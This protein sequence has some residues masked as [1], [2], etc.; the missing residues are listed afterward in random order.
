[1][2]LALEREWYDDRTPTDSD[3]DTNKVRVGHRFDWGRN[4][5][6]TSRL[7]YFDRSQFNPF[8]RLLIEE[9]LRIQHAANLLSSTNYQFTRGEQEQDVT[10]HAGRFQLTHN[11]YDNLT[12]TGH[13]LGSYQD[14]EVTEETI[15]EGGLDF[16]Y[17]K[18]I[19]RGVAFTAGLGGSYRVTDRDSTDEG[20]LTKFDEKDFVGATT[21][22]FLLDEQFIDTETIEIRDD[23]EGGG[24]L[25][26]ENV[27][28]EVQSIG[29]NQTEIIVLA[30]LNAR[31]PLT[32]YSTYDYEPEPTEKFSTADFNYNLGLDFGWIAIYRDYSRQD[33]RRISGE[34]ATSLIDR[35]D[36]RTGLELKWLRPPASAT[37][38]AERRFLK[39]G[40][41][42][43]ETYTLRESAVYS[44]APGLTL[45]LSA[46]QNF[47]DADNQ[48][49][50]LYTGDL[51]LE[52]RPPRS[53]LFVRP[54]VSA[55][56]REDKG[57]AVTDGQREERFLKAGLDLRW[58]WR[59]LSV[60]LL[61]HHQIR[62]G[63]VN[64][65]DEDRVMMTVRRS[66]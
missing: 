49:T 6:L 39:T 22:S 51:S 7:D 32:V 21:T 14:A 26:V 25:F 28:Y 42:E 31:A 54:N 63:D 27:D 65:K 17:R 16:A 53:R 34:E 59:K 33:E 57:S 61:Y 41:F 23:I 62:R 37:L 24:T 66:F 38:V 56:M 1:M 5:R 30:P 50:D 43:S 9:T 12:T 20:V 55:W 52:W 47:T 4:S 35:E 8:E 36:S 58:S 29:N 15:Y 40:S 44:F 45:N 2:S 46:S 48:D 10:E 13:A 64:E 11:L 60:D 19:F 3:S 18:Q